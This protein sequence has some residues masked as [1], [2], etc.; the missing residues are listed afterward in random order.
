M[1]KGRETLEG[2]GIREGNTMKLLREDNHITFCGER[3]VDRN[4]PE[5]AATAVELTLPT[6]LSEKAQKCW[7]YLDGT[8]F[9]YEY[10]GRLVV[11]DE[12]LE[13]TEYGD[14]SH[15]APFGAPRWECDSWEELEEALEATCDDLEQDGL[16]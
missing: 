4:N 8:A 12:S 13:L 1:P 2:R 9:A 15:E 16:L 5:L 6:G 7:D 14:G 3:P 10:Q 11:T